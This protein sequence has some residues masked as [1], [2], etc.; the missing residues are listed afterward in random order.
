M[1]LDRYIFTAISVRF[2]V[3]AMSRL[4]TLSIKQMSKTDW[5][6][7]IARYAEELVKQGWRVVLKGHYK[8]YHPNGIDQV[9]FASTPGDYCA[10][11]NIR[12]LLRRKG[13]RID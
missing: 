4:L 12:S 8:A 1:L 10:T 6:K 5:R 3:G 9:S 7:T 11:K 2:V 13:A